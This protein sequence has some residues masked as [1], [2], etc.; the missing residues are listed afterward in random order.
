MNNHVGNNLK[1][2]REIHNYT[3]SYVAKKL[4]ICE[5]TYREIEHSYSLPSNNL[6]KKIEAFYKLELNNFLN[7]D[8]DQ[9]INKLF[10]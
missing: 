4:G 7:M 8:K 9:I 10:K 5:R 3:Q 2:I 1:L 6:I